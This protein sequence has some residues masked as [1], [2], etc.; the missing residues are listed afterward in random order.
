MKRSA[1]PVVSWVD[2]QPKLLKESNRHWSIALG[3]DVKHVDAAW[4]GQSVIT[5]VV[6]KIL[7]H[8]KVAVERGK[9]QCRE[10]IFAQRT[11]VDPFSQQPL[12]FIMIAMARTLTIIQHVL[13]EY[14]NRDDWVCVRS[15][16]KWVQT[17]WIKWVRQ[18]NNQVARCRTCLSTILL[19]ELTQLNLT[20]EELLEL[21][22]FILFDMA[23]DQTLIIRDVLWTHHLLDGFGGWLVWW[24]LVA[25]FSASDGCLEIFSGLFVFLNYLFGAGLLEIWWPWL[26]AERYL[27]FAHGWASFW[28]R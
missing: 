28:C 26:R 18:V 14:A 23:E 24:L 3:S 21:L 5:S 17:L 7:D 1:H 22:M 11:R 20:L 12:V 10:P 15:C 9:M 8:E 2:I 16:M 25:W 19:V 4:V 13:A 27:F 6:E